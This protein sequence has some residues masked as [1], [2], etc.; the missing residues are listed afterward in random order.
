MMCF[1]QVAQRI[2]GKPVEHVMRTARRHEAFPPEIA[3]IVTKN[4]TFAI[5]MSNQSYYTRN[6]MF[7]VNSVININAS[8]S[9]ISSPPAG[10]SNRQVRYSRDSMPADFARNA[11][12]DRHGSTPPPSAHQNVRI[13]DILNI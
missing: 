5:T 13:L 6:K 1:G 11:A 8:Q 4:Y 7:I 2:V 9:A 3:A 12:G 10:S